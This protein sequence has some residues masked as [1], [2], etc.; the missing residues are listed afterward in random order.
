[1]QKTQ[2]KSQRRHSTKYLTV[3]SQNSKGHKKQAKSEKVSQLKRAW[4][5]IATEFNAVW[6]PGWNPGIGKKWKLKQFK[7]SISFI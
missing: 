5:D 7:Q 6:Y 4:G 2:Y 3:T 1:M